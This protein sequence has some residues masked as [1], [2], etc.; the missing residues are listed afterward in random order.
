MIGLCD[1][2]KKVLVA[3]EAFVEAG[4][5]VFCSIGRLARAMAGVIAWTG[6]IG[7]GRGMG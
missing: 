1:G 5:P 7:N 4:F 6:S 3:Q 2:M